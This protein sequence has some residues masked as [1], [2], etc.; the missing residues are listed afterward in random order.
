MILPT[1]I[2]LKFQMLNQN[3]QDAQENIRFA[4]APTINDEQKSELIEETQPQY[5]IRFRNRKLHI[6]L[7]YIKYIKYIMA[8]CMTI[9]VLSYI[10]YT[11]I[12][13]SV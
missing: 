10:L 2:E 7:K 5:T 4:L 11:V 9:G 3:L 8:I 6:K 1:R 13:Y 12:H